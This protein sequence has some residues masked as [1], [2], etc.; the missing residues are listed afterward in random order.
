MSWYGVQQNHFSHWHYSH[1][2]CLDALHLTTDKC[3]PQLF[4]CPWRGVRG[5][6]PA[7]AVLVTLFS[8]APRQLPRAARRDSAAGVEI[9]LSSRII[10]SDLITTLQ[11][12]GPLLACF[13]NHSSY[14]WI[15]TS[16]YDKNFVT[17]S[18]NIYT[19]RYC[20]NAAWIQSPLW[21]RSK[22]QQAWSKSMQITFK[23]NKQH[24]LLSYHLYLYYLFMRTQILIVT[25][26][27]SRNCS[28]PLE[29][30][31]WVY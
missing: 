29:V 6:V 11:S 16:N 26:L 28:V 18:L 4:I 7:A 14:C 9:S 2:S 12:A 25:K 23:S 19:T 15:L 24:L 20:C 22:L 13:C 3:K 27:Y 30:W 21:V 31:F 10:G 1:W 17:R 5:G 8:A